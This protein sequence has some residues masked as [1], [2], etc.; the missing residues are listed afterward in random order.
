ML[1]SNALG[2]S[3]D[4]GA[5]H[6]YQ[7]MLNKTVLLSGSHTIED[8]FFS[9][10][11][12][13]ATKLDCLYYVIAGVLWTGDKDAVTGAQ[14]AIAYLKEKVST[15]IGALVNYV[16]KWYICNL[17]AKESFLY[18]TIAANREESIWRNLK[19]WVFLHHW[20]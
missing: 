12:H 16:C 11:Y 2:P 13:K 10:P 9:T 15:H 3:R 6:M 8:C 1:W 19:N 14:D 18:Q 20:Y 5:N 4:F 17:R 7:S